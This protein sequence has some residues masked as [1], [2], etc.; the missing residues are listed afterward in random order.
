LEDDALDYRIYRDRALADGRI[1]ESEARTL[2]SFADR[3]AAR[4]CQVAERDAAAVAL[5]A[6][7]DGLRS[8][9][10]RERVQAANRRTVI[11]FPSND[12]DPDPEPVAQRAA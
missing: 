3:L 5:L 11:A 10:F 12:H 4:A 2:I 6:G 1:E 9:R 7:R 8:D